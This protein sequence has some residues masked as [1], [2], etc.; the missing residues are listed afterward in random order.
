MTGFAVRPALEFRDRL[1]IVYEG[2]FVEGGVVGPKM[3]GEVCASPIDDDPLEAVRI[4]V[5]KRAGGAAE[6]AIE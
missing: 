3:N 4:S 1:D 6:Q 2:R 5:V